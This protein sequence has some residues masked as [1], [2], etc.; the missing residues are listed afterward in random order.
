MDP[1]YLAALPLDMQ[2]EVLA[3]FQH[4]Q[5][6]TS[7][8]GLQHRTSGKGGG[9]RG[10]RGRG[11]G[12]RGRGGRGGSGGTYSNRGALNSGGGGAGGVYRSAFGALAASAGTASATSAAAAADAAAALDDVDDVYVVDDIDE[13]PAGPAAGDRVGEDMVAPLL[14]QS[15][16]EDLIAALEMCVERHIGEGSDSAPVEGDD[17]DERQSEQF[18]ALEAAAQ[19]LTAQATVGP[20]RPD[21]GSE[22]HVTHIEPLFMS[23]MAP[24]DVANNIYSALGHGASRG[25]QPGVGAARDAV[26]AAAGGQAA[27]RTVGGAVPARRSGGAGRGGAR[28]RRRPARGA[29][30]LTLRIRLYVN[31]LTLRIRLCIIP[32]TLRIR[33][34][35]ISHREQFHVS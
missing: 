5:P 28:V 2:R 17:D 26:R 22:R 25:A 19:L 27:G 31:S 8:L 1:E 6:Q 11:R 30:P 10:G 20:A 7:G 12:G 15:E 34:C 13:G 33:L 29:P 9:G 16:L 4:P 32:L 24:H 18:L 23:Y 35:I 21:I 3:Q 14:R